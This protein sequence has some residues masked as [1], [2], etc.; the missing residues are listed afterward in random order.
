LKAGNPFEELRP[1]SRGVVLGRN[2][3]GVA[4]GLSSPRKKG[5]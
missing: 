4:W 1:R 2:F 3:D 5:K